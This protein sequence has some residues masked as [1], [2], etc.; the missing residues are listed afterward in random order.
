MLGIIGSTIFG[1]HDGDITSHPSRAI[2]LKAERRS[3]QMAVGAILTVGCCKSIDFLGA[4]FALFLLFG[5]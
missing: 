5:G 2:G 3:V 1:Y 4:L